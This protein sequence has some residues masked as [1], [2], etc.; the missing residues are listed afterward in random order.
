MKTAEPAALVSG[1]VPRFFVNQK[2]TAMVNRYEIRAANPYGQPG[3]LLAFAQQKRMKLKEEVIF[4]RDDTKTEALFSFRSRQAMDLHAQTDVLDVHGN[5]VGWF[6]K[7]F[8]ASLLRSTWHLH[9]ADVEARGQERNNTVAI[10]RRFVN[11]PLRF[12]FDFRDVATGQTVMTVERRRSLRDRY[13]VSVPDPRLDV[14]LA[15]AMSVGLD[16]FQ[17]R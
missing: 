17:G 13:E 3:E 2:L 6:E 4:Y 9:Y 5:V 1:H 15:A 14:R 16:A 11:L 8:K 12:H 7:D 10:V